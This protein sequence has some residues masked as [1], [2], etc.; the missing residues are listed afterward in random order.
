MSDFKS[1]VEEIRRFIGVGGGGSQWFA[2]AYVSWYRSG[3]YRLVNLAGIERLDSNNMLLF[4]K[5]VNLRR[6][7]GW[8]DS[9]LYDLER[10][11]IEMWD[12][13]NGSDNL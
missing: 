7:R 8:N 11:A 3:D 4:W 5:M 1:V 2:H 10:Y 12:M 6:S 13:D 9:T